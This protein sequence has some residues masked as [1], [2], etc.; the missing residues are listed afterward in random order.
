MNHIPDIIPEIYPPGDTIREEL[1]TRGWTQNDLAEIMGKSIRAVNM[2]INGKAAITTETAQQ[3]AGAFGTSV[4]F[5]LNR[6]N[7]Y[8]LAQS[9][10]EMDAIR[11]RARIFQCAPVKDMQKRGWIVPTKDV[12]ELEAELNRFFRVDEFGQ[13]PEM[14]VAARTSAAP[15]EHISPAHR[16]WCQRAMWMAQSIPVPTF[17]VRKLEDVFTSLRRLTTRPEGA[18][19]VP[20]V[21]CDAGIR[22]VVI[23]HLPRSKVDGAALW[24]DSR[25]PVVALSLRFDRIDYFWHTLVHE[26]VHIRRGDSYSVDYD[27]SSESGEMDVARLEL[28][29]DVN[30]ETSSIL[31][32]QEKLDSFILRVRPFFSKKKIIQFANLNKIHPGIVAGQLQFRGEINYS[33]NKEMLVKVRDFVTE[34]AMTDGWGTVSSL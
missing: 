20:K 8:R 10:V 21:L 33:A 14:A 23:E 28:E 18:S 29:K 16:A 11:E 24:L 19:F 34:K 1:E 2:L 15:S 26:L 7:Y 32:P 25:S 31:I 17:S 27:F 6:E 3:L 4:Q 12:E 22:L 13:I 5:W 9:P 30:A